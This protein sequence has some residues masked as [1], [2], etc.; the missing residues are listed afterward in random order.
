MEIQINRQQSNAIIRVKMAMQFTKTHPK[1][2]LLIIKRF[3]VKLTAYLNCP[4]QNGIR[5]D[6]F[7]CGICPFGH[8]TECHYPNTC[9]MAKCS[10]YQRELM[11]YD[12][13]YQNEN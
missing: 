8:L 4:A 7:V 3:T 9:G 1:I 6:H 10:H 13:T 12:E 5:I 2:P 11:R